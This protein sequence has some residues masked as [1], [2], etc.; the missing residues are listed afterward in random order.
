MIFSPLAFTGIGYA[1]VLIAFYVDFYYNVIIAWSLRFFFASFTTDLPWTSCNNAW[2]T[3]DCKP[4]R[5]ITLSLLNIARF[6]FELIFAFSLKSDRRMP[7]SITRCS[8]SILQR[9]L[10]ISSKSPFN[11]AN[12][13]NHLK[14]LFFAHPLPRCHLSIPPQSLHS[15]VKS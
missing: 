13:R 15:G 9:H 4:V 5:I 8:S 7:R 10:N 3:P 14:Y 12:S 2:N 1:V 6:I 11:L